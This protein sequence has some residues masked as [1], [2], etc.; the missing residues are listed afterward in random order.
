MNE[1]RETTAIAAKNRPPVGVDDVD[2]ERGSKNCCSNIEDGAQQHQ[3]VDVVGATVEDA[4]QFAGAAT[5]FFTQLLSTG[6]GDSTE[7][8]LNGANKAR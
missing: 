3:Q 6:S 7:R 4:Q 5:F 1:I 8:G 2:E